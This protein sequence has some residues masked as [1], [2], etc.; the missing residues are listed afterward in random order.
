MPDKGS[1]ADRDLVLDIN[2]SDP[3]QDF[4]EAAAQAMLAAI[5]GVGKDMAMGD[6][7]KLEEAVDAD[8]KNI[9]FSDGWSNLEDMI[10]DMAHK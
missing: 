8:M 5:S 6:A 9:T 3:D 10:A 1:R 4:D 7:G 2:E